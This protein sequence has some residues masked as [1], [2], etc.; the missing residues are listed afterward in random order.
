MILGYVDAEDR[1]Y[2]LTFAALRMKLR[3]ETEA[4]KSIVTFSRS[5]GG[6]EARYRVLGEAAVTM[7]VALDHDG[8]P[9][10]L[11]RPVEGRFLRHEAGILIVASPATRDPDDP[12]F[13][14]V[15]VRAMPSAVKFFFEDQEG[16]EIVSIPRDEVLRIETNPAE[17][18]I[19]VSAANVALPKEKISYLVALRPPER[20]GPLLEG[21]PMSPSA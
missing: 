18:R 19:F 8:H 3:I 12:G 2:D 11:L 15:K 4:G 1:I 6:G 9:V 10:P 7:S 16:T 17:A 13:F 21:L 5:Q 20:L 14:L